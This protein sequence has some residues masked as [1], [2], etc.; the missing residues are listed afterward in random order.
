[1]E[2]RSQFLRSK[3]LVVFLAAG[4]LFAS[5]SKNALDKVNKDVNNASDVQ[6][7]FIL[8]D[9]MTST[10]FTAIGG[11]ISLY[12]SIYLEHEAGVHNQTFN[13]ETRSGEPTLST[14][15]NN[16]WT[17]IY[18]NIKNLKIAIAKTSAGGSEEGNEVTNGIAKVLL[19]YNLG[20]LTDFFGDVPFSETGVMNSDGTP[21]YM[22]PKIDK[23]S[24]LYPQ[25]QTLLDEAIV[26]LG[27]SDAAASGPMGMQ[28]LIYGEGTTAAAVASAKANWIKAAHGLKARYLM[29]TLKVSANKNGD[30]NAV[31]SNIDKSFEE[32]GEEMKFAKYDGTKYINPLFG[33]SNARDGLGASKSLVTKFS[34]LND[35]RGNPAFGKWT[36]RLDAVNTVT[37]AAA[38]SQAAPN[39]SPVQQQ[40][41]YPISY[42]DYATSAPTMLLS[43]H[44]LMFLKAEAL[45]RLNRVGEAEAALNEAV[46]AAFANFKNSVTMGVDYLA[47][48]PP[49]IN[50][51]ASVA[52]GYFDNSVKGRFNSSPLKEIM[53]Q[54]YL[55]FYGASG[56]STEA[57]NDIRRMKALGENFVEL[58][59]PLNSTSFPLRL[60][61]GNSDVTANK[62]VATAYGDGS[63]VYKENV[64]WA[65]GSR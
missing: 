16:S 5:C 14:T 21:M 63:Y 35:P 30:L 24:D 57:F 54:K 37:L 29:H 36:S 56:E 64:W 34:N 7:K 45:A 62:A 55:A 6:A 31:L 22:Q 42:I 38:L 40:Y 52:Q 49:T 28:D 2:M 20:V 26:S 43:Y 23:Q 58:A 59:N 11:D 13:A 19:A 39:G 46:I 65:G 15:N 10:A 53:L 8:T 4:F 33:Y 27:G 1:M 18:Q 44:E 41:V 60:P 25:I 47:A 61:Y 48:I 12:A 3:Y 17:G 50:L 51:S 32:V 9:V